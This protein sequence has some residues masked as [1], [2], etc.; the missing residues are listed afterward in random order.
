MKKITGSIVCSV[1]LIVAFFLPWFDVG[2]A[3]V[4]AFDIPERV[5]IVG[6]LLWLKRFGFYIRA[7]FNSYLCHY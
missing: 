4:N 3:S 1:G 6:F 7:L 2:I 5:G